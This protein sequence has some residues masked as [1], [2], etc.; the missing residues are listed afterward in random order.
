MFDTHAHVQDAAFDEDRDAVLA[1]AAAAGVERILTIGTDLADSRRAAATAARYGLDYAI[2]IHPHEAKDAP[3][4]IGAAFDALVG[5]A[6]RPPHAVGEMG[7]DYFYDHSPRDAQRRVLVAQ[8]RYARERGWP[9]VFHQRDAFDDFV[10][11]LRDEAAAPLRGVVHCFTGNAEQARLLVGE[12][13]LRLG[14]G[15]VLTFKTA[16]G[17][18]EAVLAV[19][20]EHVV[21][22]TDCPYLAPVP[23]RGSRNEPA[24]VAA[25]AARL[26]AL[27]EVTADAVVTRTNSTARSLFGERSGCGPARPETSLD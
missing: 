2:G 12:F 19:G 11:I 5:G 22:E 18:R 14:I 20:L 15:G 23:H 4:D 1:R 25:T 21:L 26:A 24:F 3:A 17:L 10:A 9:A 6:E 16:G 8:L 13:G 7:L 27:F